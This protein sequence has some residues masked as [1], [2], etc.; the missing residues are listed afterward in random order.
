MSDKA[1]MIM[2]AAERRIR[3]SGYDGFSFREIA[4]EVGVRSASVH[5]HFPTKD[6][7]AA[8]VARRYTDRFVAAVEETI[9]SGASPV[10]ACSDQFRRSLIEDGRVCLCAALGAFA[11]DLSETVAAEVRR[12]FSLTLD[13]LVVH[14]VPRGKAAHTLAALEGGMILAN[15]LGDAAVFEDVVIQ[16][17][18]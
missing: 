17:P 3:R 12:F 11:A 1:A 2:D 8:A 4:A 7:L 16:I 6:D 5:Y 18:A 13:T 15:G 9:R 14:G 10:E